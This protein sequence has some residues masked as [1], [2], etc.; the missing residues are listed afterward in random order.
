MPHQ[1][2]VVFADLGLVKDRLAV[3]NVQEGVVLFGNVEAPLVIGI[4]LDVQERQRNGLL[5][6]GLFVA[7]FARN[8]LDMHVLVV[9]VIFNVHDWNVV[10]PQHFVSWLAHLEFG[11]QIQ[12]N[13]KAIERCWLVFVCYERLTMEHTA[14]YSTVKKIH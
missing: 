14:A 4:H 11:R 6:A 9:R 13:L 7:N 2:V 5:N 1:D 3:D 8:D 10:L 12:P